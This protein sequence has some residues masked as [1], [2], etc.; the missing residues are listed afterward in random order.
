MAD[1]LE[2]RSAALKLEV[3]VVV[4]GGAK[5]THSKCTMGP[6]KGSPLLVATLAAPYNL[7]LHPSL[8]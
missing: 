1:N 5:M 6:D 8:P 4:M 2:V 3:G 7:L